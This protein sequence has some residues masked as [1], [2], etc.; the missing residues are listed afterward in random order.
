MCFWEINSIKPQHKIQNNYLKLKQG[1]KFPLIEQKIKLEEDKLL[2][3]NTK[4][5]QLEANLERVK[6]GN[7]EKE[8]SFLRE[9]HSK[10]YLQ[11]C[12]KE[13]IK[14]GFTYHNSRFPNIMEL[15]F[16]QDWNA[17]FE[18]APDQTLL[19]FQFELNKSLLLPS[20]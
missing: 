14:A 10:C 12:Y 7:I 3:I 19:S 16:T 8:K 17:I 18:F 9:C 13:E 1:H 5:T 11:P 4:V 15:A 2:K 6:A 20:S